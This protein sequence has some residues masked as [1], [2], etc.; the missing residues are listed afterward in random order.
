MHVCLTVHTLNFTHTCPHSPHHF[1]TYPLPSPTPPLITLLSPTSSP[2]PYTLHHAHEVHLKPSV[3]HS[4]FFF[5]PTALLPTPLTHL[6]TQSSFN[7]HLPLLPSSLVFHLLSYSNKHPS[8]STHTSHQHLR[9]PRLPSGTHKPESL[10]VPFRRWRG[11]HS[12]TW[13][14]SRQ[15]SFLGGCW[16][17]WGWMRLFFTFFQ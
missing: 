15:L 11:G 5:S 4:T 16:R 3:L 10:S 17:W 9:L 6:H 8:I 13:T 14:E 2:L 12:F 1:S 7:V